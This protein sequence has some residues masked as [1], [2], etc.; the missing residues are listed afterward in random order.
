MGGTTMITIS[1]SRHPSI[2]FICGVK[3]LAQYAGY[4]WYT[5]GMCWLWKY[6]VICK[7]NSFNKD[8]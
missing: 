7:Q 4:M 1:E 6:S 5:Y 2:H 8:S 3:T